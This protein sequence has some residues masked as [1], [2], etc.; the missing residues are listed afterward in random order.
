MVQIHRL[1]HRFPNGY[2]GLQDV[3]LHLEAGTFTILAGAN[4]SGK[5]TLLRHL[6]GLL[7]PT[8]G[9]VVIDGVRVDK[10]PK[11]ARRRVGMVFQDADCQIVAESVSADVAFGPENL[12]LPRAEI[13]R[14]VEKALAAVG[15]QDRAKSSP[16]LLSGGEKRR[17]A[18]A[19]ILAMDPAVIAMD[20]PFSN[21]DYP[22]TLQVL[23]QIVH[24]H[25]DGH[26]ILLATHELE[27]V[28]ALADRLVIM[29]DGRLVADAPVLEL[30]NDVAQY[31]IRPPC[32]VKY[33]QPVRS[34]LC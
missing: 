24:L 4:G 23:K 17:L 29:A 10:E 28:A 8:S 2:Q 6:N 18:I 16:H 25:K 1:S 33:G 7:C 15:L 19:G 32:A 31:G 22:A 30:L 9:W 21:L 14:R 27:K 5:S 12:R 3:D 11:R 34:W 26:T 13:D 20:E